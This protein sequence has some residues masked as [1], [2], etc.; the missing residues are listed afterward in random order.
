MK[1]QLVVLV[2]LPGS[3]RAAVARRHSEWVTVSRE[4]IRRYVFRA[5]N[6]CEYEETIDR[7][8]ATALVETVESDAPVV[9]IDD[10][11]LTRKARK[12]LL[13]LAHLSGRQPIA[14][15]MAEE[16]IDSLYAR[17]QQEFVRLRDV[18]P[19]LKVSEFPRERLTDLAR[20]YEPVTESEGFAQVILEPFPQ[21]PNRPSSPSVQPGRQRKKKREPLP[22]FV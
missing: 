2:G 7:I 19:W 10:V 4:D 20:I 1:K 14:C 11:H 22:L 17:L 3:G 16:S 6:D 13:E 12:S 9:C 18:E 5:V 21:T 8:F 15:V